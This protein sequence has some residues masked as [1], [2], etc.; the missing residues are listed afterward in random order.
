MPIRFNDNLLLWA[1]GVLQPVPAIQIKEVLSQ[2]FPSVSP[3]PSPNYI[4]SLCK[5]WVTEGAAVKIPAKPYHLFSLTYKGNSRL[6]PKLRWHRD[7]SRLFL[8]KKS[9]S[10]RIL[11]SGEQ[12]RELAGVSPA[13]DGSRYTQE[14][15]RPIKSDATSVGR[16]YWPP[17]SK[18]LLSLAGPEINSPDIFFDYYSFPTFQELRA[19]SINTTEIYDTSIYDL[20]LAIGISPRLI[21]SF[22]YA[23]ENHYR[24][25]E[26]GKRGGGTRTIKAPR[27][28]LKVLQYWISDYMLFSLKVH[29]SCHS[30][31]RGKSIITNASQHVSKAFVAN[32]DIKDFFGS[33]NTSQVNNLF[34]E[35]G[36]GE[37]ISRVLARLVTLEDALPQGA[38][39][40]PIISNSFLYEFDEGFSR[41]APFYGINYTRYA[42]DITLSGDRK[43]VIINLINE[44]TKK[45]KQYGLS[46][47][48]E[49]TRIA[50]KSGQQ[51]VTGL[52]VNVRATPPRKFRRMVRAIFH[53]AYRSPNVY[54]S[55]IPE[56]TGYLSY[57]KS[58]PYL[59][60]SKPLKEYAKTISKLR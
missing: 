11:M 56:I 41:L 55:R 49:K 42:D 15:W 1:L 25:F 24:S 34:K 14:L 17:L 21:T 38:P 37:K 27:L 10:A 18:Q 20:A 23:P 9:R 2:I 36:F 13:E 50:S 31:Q 5:S 7:K 39:T 12:L 47:N 26:I 32:L 35:N 4:E 46:I 57:L 51:R 29:T 22:L 6:F 16:F 59:E 40:S 53:N 48:K 28:F 44:L 3:L 60:D 19:A 8:L 30:Y 45:L 52:V 58:F 33:I 54:K 43:D